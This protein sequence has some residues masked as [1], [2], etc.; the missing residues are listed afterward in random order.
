[1]FKFERQG[2]DAL[3]ECGRLAAI[4]FVHHCQK[5]FKWLI[6]AAKG[7]GRCLIPCGRIG[8]RP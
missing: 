5:V 7:L 1:M 2:T 6:G 3:I 4:S 8:S